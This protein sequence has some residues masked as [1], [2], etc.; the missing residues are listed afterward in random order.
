[1]TK[2]AIAHWIFD[3]DNTLYP[4]SARLFDQI[5]IKMEAFIMR[6]L[7]LDSQSAK[8][9]R[10]DFWKKYGTTLAGLM[11][12]HD[13]DPDP[14]LDEVHDID[15][16]ALQ[17]DPDLAQLISGLPGQKLIYTNGSRGH[18]RNVSTARGLFASFD[19]IFGIEDANYVPKPHKSA[20]DAIIAKA[21]IDP[22]RAMMVEDEPRNL[23]A[24]AQ[25]GMTTV[26]VGPPDSGPHVHHSTQ[27]LAQ[28]LRDFAP[29]R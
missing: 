11:E 4:P 21:G 16:S 5:E 13:V 1:M 14:F 29:A 23:I 7:A 2:H 20:F 26:L 25:M 12:V 8:S 17:P 22:T 9:L 18:G 15:V 6:E 3:L 24:P 19:A 28:F 27:D 10:A